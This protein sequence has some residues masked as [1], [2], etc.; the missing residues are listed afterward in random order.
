[1]EERVYEMDPKKKKELNELL[2]VDPYAPTSF[3]RVAPQ[4]KEI[5]GKLMLYIKADAEFFKAAEEKLKA[6]NGARAKKE[7]EDKTI[8][9]IHDEEEAAAG[10]F[11]GIF[12]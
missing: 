12:G 7:D 3:A 11:G 6:I 1:M 8:K 2:A 5:E 9:L 4:I 10:G